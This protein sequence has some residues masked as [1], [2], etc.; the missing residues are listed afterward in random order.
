MRFF[1]VSLFLCVV[2]LLGFTSAGL[3]N[4]TD[5]NFDYNDIFRIEQQRDLGTP[6]PAN[7]NSIKYDDFFL[8]TIGFHSI[9]GIAFGGLT[10]YLGGYKTRKGFGV[11]GSYEVGAKTEGGYTLRAQIFNLSLSFTY[12]LGRSTIHLSG[13]YSGVRGTVSEVKGFRE[14]YHGSSYSITYVFRPDINLIFMG[15]A[16]LQ[17]QGIMISAGVGF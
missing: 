4:T 15:Q 2:F 5:T 11:L 14:V 10:A 7:P 8:G 3:C 16:R 17:G 12:K 9:E 13:G 1:H 6:E